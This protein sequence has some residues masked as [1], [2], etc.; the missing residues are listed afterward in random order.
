MTTKVATCPQPYGPRASESGHGPARRPRIP[1]QAHGDNHC[2]LRC[3]IQPTL[4]TA[5]NWAGKRPS[6]ARRISLQPRVVL[7]GT[8]K[9]LRARCIINRYRL[10]LSLR[11]VQTMSARGVNHRYSDRHL[12]RVA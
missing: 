2:W 5:C 6:T 9:L 4:R 3:S 8:A 11:G 7:A 12:I 1:S 10:N